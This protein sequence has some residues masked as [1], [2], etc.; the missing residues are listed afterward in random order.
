MAFRLKRGNE[1]R[2]CRISCAGSMPK[3]GLQLSGVAGEWIL[4]ADLISRLTT[5]DRLLQKPGVNDM[6]PCNRDVAYNHEVLRP[7]LTRMV[8]NPSWELFSLPEITRQ[9][10]GIKSSSVLLGISTLQ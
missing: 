3:C 2:V 10:L 9:L 5:G 1:A 6:K 4:K 7:L 8:E